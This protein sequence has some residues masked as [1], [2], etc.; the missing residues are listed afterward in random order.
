[1]RSGRG[2]GA[3]SSS[4][5]VPHV[6]TASLAQS[7]ARSPTSSA[8]PIDVAQALQTAFHDEFGTWRRPE[9][10][11]ILYS[12]QYNVRLFGIE[13]LHPFDSCKFEKVRCKHMRDERTA[14]AHCSFCC[15]VLWRIVCVIVH[16]AHPP[17]HPP[18][19]NRLCHTCWLLVSLTASS[20]L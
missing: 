2:L 20:N 12:R 1:M 9:Q 6:G 11:P 17:T 13:K 19:H 8:V 16:S 7:L 5:P 10:L 18:T 4:T 15:L 3:G 14:P